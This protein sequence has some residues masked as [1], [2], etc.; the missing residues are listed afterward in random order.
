VTRGPLAAMKPFSFLAT[1]A[2]TSNAVLVLL[3]E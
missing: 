1:A 3:S 2:Q